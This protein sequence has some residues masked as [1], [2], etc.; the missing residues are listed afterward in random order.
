[1]V[2]WDSLW[3][4]QVLELCK[5]D[6]DA[7]FILCILLGLHILLLP[8]GILLLLCPEVCVR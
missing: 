1:M 8:L 6:F 5:L 4:T 2:L 3:K 7:T